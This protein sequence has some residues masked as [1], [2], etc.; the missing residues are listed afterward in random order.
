MMPDALDCQK[1]AG[2]KIFHRLQ[3]SRIEQLGQVE[4]A[5]LVKNILIQ[6]DVP[7]DDDLTSTVTTLGAKLEADTRVHDALWHET[8]KLRAFAED[9]HGTLYGGDHIEGAVTSPKCL[10]NMHHRVEKLQRALYR[11]RERHA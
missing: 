11:S 5:N 6:L 9:V 7:Y 1:S 4:L 3:L 2:E 8:T 10:Q